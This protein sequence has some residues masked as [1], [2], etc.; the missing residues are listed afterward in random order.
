V[1][2][3]FV[4][5][6]QNAPVLAI[7]DAGNFECHSQIPNGTDSAVYLR[8]RFHKTAQYAGFSGTLYA[9]TTVTEH[10]TEVVYKI[11]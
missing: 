6:L 2:S 5:L 7:I 1:K 9:C 4:C 11:E 8:P 10:R 3:N